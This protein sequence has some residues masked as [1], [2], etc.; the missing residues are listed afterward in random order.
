MKTTNKGL[1]WSLVDLQTNNSIF[2]ICF[3]D[4]I[5]G[6]ISSANG[7]IYKTT[8]K[9]ANWNL[10][11]TNYNSDLLCIFFLNSLTGYAGGFNGLII[12]TTN[13]G[14]NWNNLNTGVTYE[15]DG[16]AS[17]GNNV[18]A[19][20]STFY[21]GNVLYSSNAGNNWIST[22]V[23]MISVTNVKYINNNKVIAGGYYSISNGHYYSHLPRIGLSSNGGLTWNFFPANNTI[24]TSN[25]TE[26]RSFQFKD[27]LF[28]YACSCDG[29][30]RTT[31]GGNNWTTPIDTGISLK[32]IF[33][34][35]DSIINGTGTN[36][37][38]IRTTNLGN[39]WFRLYPYSKLPLAAGYSYLKFF[40]SNNGILIKIYDNKFY[41]TTDGGNNWIQKT[42]PTGQSLGGSVYFLNINTGYVQAGSGIAK[43]TNCGDN[44]NQCF[45]NPNSI[46]DIYF[47]NENTGMIYGFVSNYSFAFKTTDGGLN[48]FQVQN[49][50]G[51]GQCVYMLDSSICFVTSRQIYRS[52]NSG[53]NWYSV[54]DTSSNINCI[55][56][57][58]N[59]GFA[60]CW[61]GI[62]RTSNYGQNWNF[63]N[64]SKTVTNIHIFNSAIAIPETPYYNDGSLLYTTNSGFNWA[65]FKIDSSRMFTR[66][67]FPS[68]NTG[69]IMDDYGYML[70][71]TTAGTIWVSN[72]D[73]KIPDKYILY[74]NYPN[75][76]NPWTMI[77]YD[78][79][80]D[81]FVTIK[82]YDM[83]GREITELVGENE[84][85]GFY[86]I[87][88]NGS[89]LS[90]GMY[91]Y[92]IQAGSYSQTKKM[93]LIK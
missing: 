11:N 5:N 76:F 3:P 4:T 53:T 66:M 83:L 27:S 79:P 1:N 18:S 38:I 20:N 61:P 71:T 30:I 21:S 26:V 48:W 51:N 60:G 93:V 62:L 45:S 41:R 85:A 84:K 90:S 52:T 14:I 19:V 77:K 50:E 29:L 32:N 2:V 57:Y 23:P 25:T 39:Y 54:S 9:G 37:S 78:I 64:L 43:T 46:V 56:F 49:I 69:Y 12:K 86:S 80:K 92:K 10:L 42:T 74:Q 7:K 31:N 68:A 47:I 55:T 6:F 65:V 89:N 8:N 67:S 91:L 16:I 35:G 82:I 28:G 63:I 15:I 36:G 24:S 40:D 17:R 72:I 44:W 87:L 75:P 13:G 34:S 73:Y 88:F 70:K 59:L 58:N 22:A 33:W 81:G